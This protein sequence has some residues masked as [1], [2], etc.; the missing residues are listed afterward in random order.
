M[1]DTKDAEF[2]AG[3]AVTATATCVPAVSGMLTSLVAHAGAVSSAAHMGAVVASLIPGVAPIIA[4]FG[5]IY[6]IS[7]F[8]EES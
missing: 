3:A 5:G 1:A 8:I 2:A 4:V 6:A 7:R